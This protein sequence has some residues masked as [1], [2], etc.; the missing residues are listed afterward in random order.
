MMYTIGGPKKSDT[1]IFSTNRNWAD[2]I[3]KRQ[4]ALI[5]KISDFRIFLQAVCVF[6]YRKLNIN[7]VKLIFNKKRVLKTESASIIM[8]FS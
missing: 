3:M 2:I 7:M 4:T 5:P 8:D 6:T 1:P